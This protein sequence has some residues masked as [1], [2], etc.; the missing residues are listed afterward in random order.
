M[1]GAP[2]GAPPPDAEPLRRVPSP[3]RPAR[4]APGTAVA[5]TADPG[6]HGVR[7]ARAMTRSRLK[8]AAIGFSVLF[9]AVG[10]KLADATIFDPATPRRVGAALRPVIAAATEPTVSRGAIT[11][12]NG[13]ILAVSLPIT[14]LYANP[15]VIENP[16]SVAL[17]LAA[18]LPQLDVDL[19]TARLSTDRQF[20][21]LARALTP[22]EVAAVNG[23]GIPGLEFQEAER[24]YYPQG[25]AAVHAL[26]AVDVDGNGIAG[27][28]R[29]F[30]ER[31]R[32]RAS[33]QLRLSL[34]IRVQLALREAVAKA[35]ADYSGIGGAGVVLD[36]R[37]S[38]VISMV[39]LPD[40]DQY[41][42]GSATSD[43]RFNRVTVGLYEPGS[44][45]K[46]FTTAMAL[47]AGTT[48]VMGGYDAASPIRI[49]RF[50]ISDYRGKGRW[51]ALPEILAYSSNL[52][53][54]HMAEA[55]GTLRHR[56]FM[57]AAGLLDRQRIELPETATPLAPSA[58]SWREVNTLTIGFGHGI[59]VT[60]LHVVNGVAA[61]ANGGILRRPTI[62]AHPDGE[63]REGIRLVSERTSETIRRLM[64]LVVTDGSGRSAEVPGYFVGG[65]TGTAQ[66]TGPNGNYLANKRIAAFVGAFPMYA[67][68]YAVYV[69][70][71]EPS[72]NA[73]SHGFAT[74]GWVAAPA[75]HTVISRIAPILGLVPEDPANPALIAATRMPLQPRAS[76][77]PP[78]TAPAAE[79]GT[80]TAAVAAMNAVMPRP[81][82]APAARPG[83]AAEA[84][85]ARRPS[86]GAAPARPPSRATT[87]A[88][89]PR[90]HRGEP[91]APVPA[92]ILPPP[93]PINRASPLRLTSGEPPALHQAVLGP[94]SQRDA[95]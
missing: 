44:T 14:A 81:A 60:P 92:H 11:D 3:E 17:R 72:P 74:A 90:P 85:P 46:L 15:R 88:T 86:G 84:E 42:L 39:S 21:Y 37:T 1:T 43:Q 25:R 22:R 76:G 77:A 38:E 66:K 31:L 63:E 87:G 65:K 9:G 93:V 7:A 54:A 36:V 57:G 75:A 69:M 45:F 20:A 64:R 94:E 5:S 59:S 68:R 80:I 2:R 52:G 16:R 61:L 6:L 49:G 91:V 83:T 24:R 29:F 41:D 56:A 30:D 12:R 67:P 23:L 95:R 62:L 13:E 35:I 28:E 71:D 32:L 70:V 51:L 34:D 48:T 47:E 50:T 89:P 27:V 82:A 73:M 40:F 8:F 78:V 79:P 53:A 19:V 18:V 33:D 26:G 58:R 10:L 55:V 4:P